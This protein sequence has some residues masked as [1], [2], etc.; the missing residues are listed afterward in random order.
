VAN[1]GVVAGWEL[2]GPFGLDLVLQFV[3]VGSQFHGMHLDA[4]L[5]LVRG[6]EVFAFLFILFLGFGT[7]L[8][9]PGGQG[10]PHLL[11]GE[12]QRAA[13]Q[14]FLKGFHVNLGINLG[15]VLPKLFADVHAQGV[16]GFFLGR[17]EGFLRGGQR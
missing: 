7:Q 12:E 3:G 11:V 9:L 17:F 14:R 4:L 13:G 1:D 15:V 5:F 16:A 8:G 2:A 6:Q 10:F